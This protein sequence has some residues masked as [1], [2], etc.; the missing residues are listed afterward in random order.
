[1]LYLSYKNYINFF[2]SED[3]FCHNK[4]CKYICGISPGSSL[5]AK[6]CIYE[7][8]VYN[9]LKLIFKD[10]LHIT[11]T[12]GRKESSSEIPVHVYKILIWSLR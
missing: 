7:S 8:I 1:M 12:S 3:S 5:F 9:G 2:V 11:G 10:K 6:V 4:Q